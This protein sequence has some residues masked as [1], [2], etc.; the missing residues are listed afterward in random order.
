[1][2]PDENRNISKQQKETSNF[3]FENK[4]RLFYMEQSMNKLFMYTC[5]CIYNVLYIN[6]KN[7]L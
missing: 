5:M 1:M 7:K 3:F 6:Y 2:T 4:T